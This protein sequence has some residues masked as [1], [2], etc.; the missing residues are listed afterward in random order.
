MEEPFLFRKL[1]VYS[2]L[3]LLLVYVLENFL[4]TSKIQTLKNQSFRKI[5]EKL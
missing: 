5:F 3:R 2:N 4:P 1:F